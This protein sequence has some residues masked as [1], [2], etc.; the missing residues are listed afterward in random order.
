MC[1]KFERSHDENSQQ[2][3]GHVAQEAHARK[4]RGQGT[5]ALKNVHERKKVNV[6]WNDVARE[7]AHFDRQNQME[8]AVRRGKV[9][10]QR[11]T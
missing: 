1:K 6:A 10:G 3:D 2:P 7:F 11:R 9:K 5:A 4:S 8:R